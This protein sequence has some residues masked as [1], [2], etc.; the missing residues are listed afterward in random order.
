MAFGMFGVV[1]ALPNIIT[2]FGTDVQTVQ[3]IMTGYLVARV[4]PMPAMGWLVSRL[5]QRNLYVLGVLGTTISTVLCGLAWSVESLIGFR[6][7]QGVAGASVMTIG[8]VMLYEA[9]PPEQ[10]GLAM[11]LFIMVASLGPTLGQSV[12]GYL[13]QQFSWRAIFFLALPS[14]VLGTVL[15]L[16]RIPH[17][18]PATEK[19]VDV[20][21]L[22]TMTIFLVALLLALSQGQQYGW[23]SRYILGL[24]GISSVFLGLFIVTELRVAHP[25]VHL[26]LYRNVPFVLASM[27]VF[28]YNAGFMG[29]NFLVA[30]MV[31]LILD[32]TPMQAGIIL[33]PG[34][35]VMG[36][37][38]LMAGRLSDRLAPHCLVC[39][40]LVLFAIDMYCFSRLSQVVSIGT[41]TLLVILQRGAFG[42]IFSASDTA[43]MRTLPVTDR[44]MGVG[45]HNMHRGIAMA[46]GVTLGSVL[47][48]KR[49]AFHQLLSEHAHLA[50][51]QDCLLV[52]G[53]GF[54]VALL[55]AWWSRTRVP[56]TP[57]PLSIPQIESV[58]AEKTVEE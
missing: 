4:I 30:L 10:R 27:V 46:F 6:V 11:G 8:M 9:F 26:R 20:P 21:G 42:M 32:F 45:L 34:A 44:S 15:P 19:T 31:Q 54:L 38:G 28:L 5:G 36:V 50:A 33:A 41:M 58:P 56:H 1:V 12:G 52:I 16:T 7:V 57:Q 24:L 40:G 49:L 39:A 3:W 17:T 37:I 18:L 22:G 53:V 25:V 43:I 2:A 29:A 14:G 48:E 13:V 23:D 55:P 35:L 51:Y 47:L